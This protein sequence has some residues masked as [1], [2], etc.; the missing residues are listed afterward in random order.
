MANDP[1]LAT[2]SPEVQALVQRVAVAHALAKDV[3][4]MI[5]ALRQLQ[6]LFEEASEGLDEVMSRHDDTVTALR[7][8]RRSL[9]DFVLIPGSAELSRWN[10]AL[11]VDTEPAGS[12]PNG[13]SSS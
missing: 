5:F 6:P 13:E 9:Y 11:V 2:Q 3:D 10:I 4:R 8:L 7:H 1:E 12:S